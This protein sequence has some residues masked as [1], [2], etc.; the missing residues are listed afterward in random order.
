MM[1]VTYS[2]GPALQCPLCKSEFVGAQI[3]SEPRDL[4]AG[5][6][7]LTMLVMVLSLTSPP[8]VMPSSGL[9]LFSSKLVRRLSN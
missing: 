6:C 4:T 3:F 5:S 7:L 9:N 1:K 2:K 8:I